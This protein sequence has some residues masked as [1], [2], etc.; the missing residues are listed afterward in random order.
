M[1][2]A[3]G[4]ARNGLTARWALLM[5]AATRIPGPQG[6]VDRAGTTMP[7]EKKQINIELRD[8]EA[9]GIYANFA[10]LTNSPAEFVMDF[11]RVLPGTKKSRVHARIV[12]APP[13]AKALLR[14]LEENIKKYESRHGE[15]KAAGKQEPGKQIGFQ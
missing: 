6:G 12:M 2:L 13:N 4:G 15:I 1:R 8:E 7:G 14:A 10:V 5:F 11:I 3:N 9:E